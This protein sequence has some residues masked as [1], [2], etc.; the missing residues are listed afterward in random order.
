MG[1][2]GVRIED[3]AAMDVRG[4]RS[5]VQVAFEGRADSAVRVSVDLAAQHSAV[6]AWG[7]RAAEALAEA[8]QGVEAVANPKEVVAGSEVAVGGASSIL[9]R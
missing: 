6:Q 9:R 4:S 7:D 8:G 2:A 3:G 5:V 1:G